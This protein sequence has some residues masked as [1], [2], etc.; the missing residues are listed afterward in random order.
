MASY[1]NLDGNKGYNL[2]WTINLPA[3]ILGEIMCF[4]DKN[5]L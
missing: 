1:L 4:K 5:I 3:I 2:N